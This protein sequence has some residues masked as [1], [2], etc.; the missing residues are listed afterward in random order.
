MEICPKICKKMI[1]KFSAE[2]EIHQMDSWPQKTLLP[3]VPVLSFGI[4]S[5]ANDGAQDPAPFKDTWRTF[6]RIFL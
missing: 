6:H 5:T 3:P 2:M 4:R 1:D